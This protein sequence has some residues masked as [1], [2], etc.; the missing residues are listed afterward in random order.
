MKL[1]I[2]VNFKGIEIYWGERKMIIRSLGCS[3]D[4]LNSNGSRDIRGVNI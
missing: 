2:F 4:I 3:K 1:L